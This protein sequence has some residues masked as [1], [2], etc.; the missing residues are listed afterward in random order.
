MSLSYVSGLRNNSLHEFK[1]FIQRCKT[2]IL[3]NGSQMMPVLRQL[4]CNFF[5]ITGNKGNKH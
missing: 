2:V 5:L 1:M 4:L 3:Y